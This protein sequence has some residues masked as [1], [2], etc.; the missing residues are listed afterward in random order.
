ML[1][2]NKSNMPKQKQNNETQWPQIVITIIV[3]LWFAMIVSVRIYQKRNISPS[4]LPPPLALSEEEKRRLLQELVRQE[5]STLS[6]AQKAK[7]VDE[8][9]K[10]G[11]NNLTVE[12]KKQLLEQLTK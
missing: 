10:S 11:T 7:L 3:I 8:V 4:L 6:K 5:T 1:L 9:A 12:E 2:G